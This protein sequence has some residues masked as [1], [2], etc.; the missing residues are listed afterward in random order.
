MR[1]IVV[2]SALVIF[3]LAIAIFY[4]FRRKP[5]ESPGPQSPSEAAAGKEV[6]AFI[7]E[8]VVEGFFDR[9]TIV[10][11][12]VEI[13]EDENASTSL[14]ER[15]PQ[16]VDEALE[17]HSRDQARWPSVTD[18]DRLDRAFQELEQRGIVARQNF[19]CC[20]TC[21]NSE[22]GEPI[23]EARK[24]GPV[25]GYV[26]YHEQD[27]ERAGS[28]QELYLASGSVGGTEE[29]ALAVANT[30]VEKLENQGLTV[31]WEGKLDKRIIVEL[32]W[33]RRRSRAGEAWRRRGDH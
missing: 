12:A 15:I 7:R 4:L 27:T 23:A 20:Q 18:C 1:R 28:G 2:L 17:S 19:A 33:K 16:M 30:I 24:K 6:E 26:Y 9:D 5:S 32:D 21:G 3:G 31:R 14:V 11:Y 22:I 10:Q 13:A 29:D 25:K 8:K